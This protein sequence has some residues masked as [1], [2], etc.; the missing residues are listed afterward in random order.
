MEPINKILFH[1]GQY[2][3][4]K[5]GDLHTQYGL[6]KEDVLKKAKG[7]ITSNIGK[8]F[9]VLE[10]HFTDLI[11]KATRGPQ[12]ITN[13]DIGLILT[14]TGLN[15]T[16]VVLESGTGSGFLTCHLAKI[17]KKVITYER[18]DDFQKIAKDN[19][20]LLGFKNITFKLKDIYEGIEEKNMDTIIL[21]LPEPWRV[22]ESSFN[23][24]KTGGYFVVY[25]PGIDQV[26]TFIKEAQKKFFLIKVTELLQRE[27]HVEE[28]RVRPESQMMGHTGFLCFL[29]KL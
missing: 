28:G 9:N 13:K 3:A 18:R 25:V 4:W 14:E 16:S 8:E 24:L 10:P 5:K 29:R 12:I 2:F 19:G 20:A 26:S 23:A 7:I 17:V 11:K 6:L 15:K 22:V 21:D 1:N 27:W